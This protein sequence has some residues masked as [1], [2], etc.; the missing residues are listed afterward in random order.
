MTTKHLYAGT[1][2]AVRYGEAI[3]WQLAE[4]VVDSLPHDPL[5]RV[6]KYSRKGKR[7]MKG[8]SRVSRD[9]VASLAQLDEWK[10][11]AIERRNLATT[12]HRSELH[13]LMQLP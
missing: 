7:W 13:R 12:S 1:Y 11:E 3:G 2:L 6:R 9:R 8:V 10:W 5:V 4:V